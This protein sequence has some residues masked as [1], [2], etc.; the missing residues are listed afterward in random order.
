[1]TDPTDLA[2]WLSAQLD[3]DERRIREDIEWWWQGHS[4]IDVYGANGALIAGADDYVRP[5]VDP[6]R[7]LRGIEA[8]RRLVERMAEVLHLGWDYYENSTVIELA[9]STLRALAAE[10]ADRPGYREEWAP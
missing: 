8:K 7:V 1:M 3:E 6:G 5:L 10:Y 9:E 2:E 4:R